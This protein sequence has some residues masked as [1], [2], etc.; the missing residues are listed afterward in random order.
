MC[1][2]NWPHPPRLPG[3]RT[4]LADRSQDPVL[5]EVPPCSDRSNLSSGLVKVGLRS[6]AACVLSAHLG[7]RERVV[8]WATRGVPKRGG[9]AG[10]GNRRD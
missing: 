9:R 2:L 6:H 7:A 10:S 8:L 5:S 4:G 3:A 1:F